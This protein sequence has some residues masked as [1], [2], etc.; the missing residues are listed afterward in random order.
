[1][2]T[3]I[4]LFL[5]MMAFAAEAQTSAD[6]FRMGSEKLL[7]LRTEVETLSQEAQAESRRRQTELEALLQRRTELT[8]QLQKEE[9]RRE[10]LK[11]KL[12]VESS[13]IT[14]KSAPTRE[15]R[16]MLVG[17]AEDLEN[18]IARSLPFRT[19]ERLSQ[20]RALKTKLKAENNLEPL[21]SQLWS[22]T[23]QELK[24]THQNDFEVM[25]VSFPEG[26]QKAEVA[27]LGMMQM[28]ALKT[29]GE[30]VRAVRDAEVWKWQAAQNSDE[31]KAIERI[32]RRLSEQ[33]GQGY[34]QIPGL[35]GATL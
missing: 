3:W 7:Q 21:V 30:A 16:R 17:W 26:R 2:K 19:E 10:Q 12:K 18:W 4:I 31:K 13:K 29:N 1:M 32:C 6:E 34:F 20:V 25:E 11:E 28:Y 22:L 33:K 9:M 27:R 23:D 35:E 14:S 24:L 8:S 5:A 15:D